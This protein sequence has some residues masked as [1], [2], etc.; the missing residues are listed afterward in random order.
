M[1]GRDDH[2]ANID[3][4]ELL[5]CEPALVDHGSSPPVGGGRERDQAAIDPFRW[6]R[7]TSEWRLPDALGLLLALLMPIVSVPRLAVPHNATP[8]LATLVV[9]G[10]AGIPW[11][12]WL[13][14]ARKVVAVVAVLAVGWVPL[15]IVAHPRPYLPCSARWGRWRMGC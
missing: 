13:A 14:A 11:L 15:T 4:R 3:R 10:I 5:I 7:S 1:T 6:M 2:I 12:L 9:V 8:R